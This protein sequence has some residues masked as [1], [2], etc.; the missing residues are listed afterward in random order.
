MLNEK[1]MFGETVVFIVYNNVISP[2]ELFINT[3]VF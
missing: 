1:S 3:A 2:V